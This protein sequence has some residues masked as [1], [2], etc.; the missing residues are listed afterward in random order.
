MGT[1]FQ[2]SPHFSIGAVKSENTQVLSKHEVSLG[3]AESNKLSAQENNQV[4]VMRPSS[5]LQ[6]SPSS[7]VLRVVQNP[8]PLQAPQNNRHLDGDD[9]LNNTSINDKGID[10]SNN[11]SISYAKNSNNSFKYDDFLPN[12]PKSDVRFENRNGN[13]V[14]AGPNDV[15]DQ[16]VSLPIPYA[17]Q[18]QEQSRVKVNEVLE[19]EAEQSKQVLAPPN[20]AEKFANAVPK[21]MNAHNNL[22]SKGP[23]M[24]PIL[25]PQAAGQSNDIDDQRDTDGYPNDFV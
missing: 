3:N 7:E 23:L 6:V 9:T 11:S 5:Q 25:K 18:Q 13:I 14:P 4:Q 24:V 16:Y 15:R 22:S 12:E 17:Q 20:D 21:K 2:K 1:F 10:R 8:Q 19:D